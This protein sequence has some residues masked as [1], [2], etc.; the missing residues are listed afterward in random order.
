MQNLYLL[1]TPY[2]AT[3]F[4]V[5]ANQNLWFMQSTN[6]VE[7]LH[8]KG[9]FDNKIFVHGIKMQLILILIIKILKLEFFQKLKTFL[10]FL[11][12]E[13]FSSFYIL[14]IRYFFIFKNKCI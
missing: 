4:Y 13:F 1:S 14:E 12:N 7:V 10:F 3:W 8:V 2:K 11:K 5:A 6:S 9:E